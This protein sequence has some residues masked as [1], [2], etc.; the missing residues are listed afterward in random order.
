MT[1]K[2]SYRKS[3]SNP[4]EN[5]I[6]AHPHKHFVLSALGLKQLGAGGYEGVLNEDGGKDL[7]K[8]AE[9]SRA[10]EIDE[11]TDLPIGRAYFCRT[12]LFK[13]DADPQDPNG[14]YNSSWTYALTAEVKVGSVNDGESISNVVWVNV[15]GPNDAPEAVVIYTTKTRWRNINMREA[16]IKGIN[17]YLNYHEVATWAVKQQGPWTDEEVADFDEGREMAAAESL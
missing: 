1:I 5:Y 8:I 4:D 3:S 11:S 15:K 9:F 2:I 17:K 14:P 7:I 16:A 10:F 12:K 6:E 13:I